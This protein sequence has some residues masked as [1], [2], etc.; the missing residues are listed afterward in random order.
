MI[1]T[2]DMSRPPMVWLKVTIVVN[3]GS[4]RVTLQE[5][6]LPIGWLK[7]RHGGRNVAEVR[8]T[9]SNDPSDNRSHAGHCQ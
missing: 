1:V 4:M 9:V 5:S 3:T 6:Q 7:G 2:V 8:F